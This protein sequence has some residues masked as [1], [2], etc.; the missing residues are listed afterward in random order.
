LNYFYNKASGKRWSTSFFSPKMAY[1]E[2][3]LKHTDMLGEGN[4][5][6]NLL[7]VLAYLYLGL[8]EYWSVNGKLIV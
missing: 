7:N 5:R 2:E 6:F 3:I 4:Y 8:I 1:A